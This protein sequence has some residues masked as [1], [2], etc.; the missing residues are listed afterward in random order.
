MHSFPYCS[1]PL[2]LLL[3]VL[4]C[5]LP[6]QLALA[7]F[8]NPPYPEN[9]TP[10]NLKDLYSNR[11]QRILSTGFSRLQPYRIFGKIYTFF[12]INHSVW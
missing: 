11:I 6:N 12:A 9:P 5:V 2:L 7:Y 4:E 8:P 3:V 1:Q 10:D